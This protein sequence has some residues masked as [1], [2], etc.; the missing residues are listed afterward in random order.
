MADSNMPY[1][2]RLNE[3]SA[4][5]GKSLSEDIQPEHRRQAGLQVPQ[6]GGFNT[7]PALCRRKAGPVNDA[8]A[9]P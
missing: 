4:W 1:G 3:A 2:Q 7:P 6:V 8:T 5:L 9:E